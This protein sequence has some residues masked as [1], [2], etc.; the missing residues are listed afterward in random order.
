MAMDDSV[1]LRN[2]TAYTGTVLND[3][4]QLRVEES[5]DP[6]TLRRKDLVMIVFRSDTG[7][8]L[9]Q[10]TLKDGTQLRGT[11]LDPAVTIQPDTLG[12]ITLKMADILAIQFLA[13]LGE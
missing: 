12:K 5:S 8:T 11:I 3:S 10:A 2:G 1:Q 9:D 4:F 7:D 13:G 6:L